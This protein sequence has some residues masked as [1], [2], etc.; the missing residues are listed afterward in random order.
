MKIAF[1]LQENHNDSQLA[2]RFGRTPWFGVIDDTKPEEVVFIENDQKNQAHGAGSGAVQL[3]SDVDLVIAP[4]VGP[5]ALTTLQQ[6][7]ID[8]FYQGDS[9]NIK[10]GLTR[11]QADK[12]TKVII[13]KQKH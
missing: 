7:E 6:L 2:N 8:A 5:N 12:L 13:P 1:C 3:I 4:E 10:E 9:K 11:W